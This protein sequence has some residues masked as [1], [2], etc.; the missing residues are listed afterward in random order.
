[1]PLTM[2]SFVGLALSVFFILSASPIALIALVAADGEHDHDHAAP[3]PAPELGSDED[4]KLLD[5]QTQEEGASVDDLAAPTE[6]Q[7]NPYP[8][9]HTD[10]HVHEKQNAIKDK[11]FEFEKKWSITCDKPLELRMQNPGPGMRRLFQKCLT[12][13]AH[14][15]ADYIDVVSR[16]VKEMVQSLRHTHR[17]HPSDGEDHGLPRDEIVSDGH[18]YTSHDQLPHLADL[19]EASVSI[20]VQVT[21]SGI[22]VWGSILDEKMYAD[23][24]DYTGEDV[25]HQKRAHETYHWAGAVDDLA[26]VWLSLLNDHTCLRYI[27]V[28]R[29]TRVVDR[30]HAK[31]F[32]YARKYGSYGVDAGVRGKGNKR[33]DGTYGHATNYQAWYNLEEHLDL[34]IKKDIKRREEANKRAHR[35]DPERRKSFRAED[36]SLSHEHKRH[37]T[38]KRGALTPTELS[39]RETY[40]KIKIEDDEHELSVDNFKNQQLK[41]RRAAMKDGL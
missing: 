38:R 20:M 30:Q 15:Y 40:M 26:K 33:R 13:R 18:V 14:H 19:C 37:R 36:H 4:L 11:F 31:Y 9:P 29:L 32:E 41:E 27:D 34:W 17:V 23:D 7:T 10:E 6:D 25:Q 2:K 39:M 28:Y 12:R 8:H 24:I 5:E 16:E 35:A 1:M 22:P 21:E 3:V